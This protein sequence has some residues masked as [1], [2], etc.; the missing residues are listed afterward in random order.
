MAKKTKVSW[1]DDSR[2]SDLIA[3]YKNQGVSV[4]LK[5]GWF[6]ETIAWMLYIVTFTLYK[7]D[8]FLKQFA[9]TIG[10][11]VGFPRDWSFRQVDYVMPHE[12]QHVRQGKICGLCISPWLGLLP[13]G[14]LY[15]L[16]PIPA[17]FAYFRYLF[18]KD[19]TRVTIQ[20]IKVEGVKDGKTED[21]I[22]E[23]MHKQA[24]YS[25]KRVSSSD[26]MWSVPQSFALKGYR[27]M[28]KKVWLAS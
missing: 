8:K 12:G 17:G 20:K 5:E 27:K 11:K 19:A 6:W 3:L 1:V 7:R 25:A 22:L 13:F 15:I 18:E 4:E 16:L 24:E 10:N 28:V 2:S 14:I 9:T 26:Y 21:E 23:E